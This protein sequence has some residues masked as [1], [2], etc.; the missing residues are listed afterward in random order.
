MSAGDRL[1]MLVPFIPEFLSF[2]LLFF[3]EFLASGSRLLGMPLQVLILACF[4]FERSLSSWERFLSEN[5][6]DVNAAGKTFVALLL[7]KLEN[8]LRIHGRY[9]AGLDTL[10]VTKDS[11]KMSGFQLWKGQ[12]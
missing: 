2:P 9:L 1:N 11:Q 10:L 5:L 12:S 8:Q 3:P 7:Q 6:W 4:W